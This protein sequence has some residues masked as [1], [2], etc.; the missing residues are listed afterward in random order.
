MAIIISHTL[1]FDKHDRILV[2]CRSNKEK[3]FPGYWDLPGGTVRLKEDPMVGAIREVK[4]ECGLK[5]SDLRLFVYT[6]NWDKVKQ[7]KFVT[8]IFKTYK[9]SGIIKLN[10]NDHQKYAWLSKAEIKKIK[11]VKYFKEIFKYLDGA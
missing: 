8:L 5:V 11:R 2:L 9:Y 6:S 1:I 4:E 7:E 10:L 3:I